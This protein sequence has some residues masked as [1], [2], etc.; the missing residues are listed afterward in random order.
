M[1]LTPAFFLV[2]SCAV[3]VTGISK[4]GFGGG[5]GVMAVPLMSLYV[6][7][8]LAVAILMPILLAMDILIVW[9]Y[10]HRWSRPAVA[11]LLPGA[12]AGLIAG[13]LAFQWMS[14]DLI[15]FSVG[16]L[17]LVFVAQY[18]HGARQRDAARPTPRPIVFLLGSISGFASF[19]AHAGGP[20]VKGILLRQGLE[21]SVFV[22]TNTMF[23]FSLNATK[24]VAYSAMGQLTAESLRLS[25]ILAPL[26]FVGI[27]LGLL[28]HRVVS[29][30]IFTRIVYTF[31]FLAGLKLLWDGRAVITG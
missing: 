29:Q 10:R 20:P 5:L 18:L 12:A 1:D 27:G 16:L 11:A 2:A 24:S 15:R 23:F 6:A 13:A 17:A 14:A 8:Q 7:P 19:V 30:A 21:K 9:Q 3:L 25:L 26:L 31:L 4:S 28:L 22:G